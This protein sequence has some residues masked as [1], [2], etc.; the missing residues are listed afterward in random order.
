LNWATFNVAANHNPT[1]A[2]AGSVDLVGT[3]N[4]FN[5]YSISD[6]SAG[7]A[8]TGGAITIDQ[9]L[10]RNISFYGTGFY[11]LRRAIIYNQDNNNQFNSF[12]V[13]TLNP[14][15]PTG[16]A[17]TN[18]RVAYHMSIE[19]PSRSA[20]NELAQR[21]LLGLN[22]DLP[23]QWAAQIYYSETRDSNW[24]NV[25]GRVSKPAVSAA[26][27]WTIPVTL[28]TG[29]KPAVATFTKP[30]SV[31]YLNLF[32]DPRSIA[33]NS[34]STLAYINFFSTSSEAY[35]VNEKAVKADGPLFS[36]PGGDVKAAIGASY[37]S[38]HY[39]ITQLTESQSNTSVDV[40]ND[41]QNRSVWAVYAQLNVPVFSD[42]NA[43]PFFRRL[44][45]EASW[46][47]DQYSDFGGTSNQK[48]GFNWT[49]IDDLTLRGGW[50]TSFRAPNFG[51]N[52]N[53]VNAAWN[54]FGLPP[55]IFSNNNTINLPCVNGQA[56]PGS[57]AKN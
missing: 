12:A 5:P 6:Y 14:Y 43:I 1:G 27:G 50:G 4:E 46:R 8:Y 9:R 23:A 31:P 11:G 48:I 17:P 24:L 25:T 18:L 32:C 20:G 55:A 44:D 52:S 22:I 15:Y 21:Y 54:G 49:P 19:S 42:Q 3:R 51:E 13:P 40:F 38:N 37:T 34:P 30:A 26:L 33:C 7:L 41:P 47:H 10:T 56:T 29:S 28:P 36:L 39:I 16:G 57:G 35:W 53:L 45:L 2:G